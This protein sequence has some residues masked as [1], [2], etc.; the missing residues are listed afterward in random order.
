MS[1]EQAKVSFQKAD[2]SAYPKSKDVYKFDK[3]LSRYALW[4]QEFELRK[5]LSD[6]AADSEIL[7]KIGLDEFLSDEI[8]KEFISE[9]AY[10]LRY[11]RLNDII[12]DAAN[13][14]AKTEKALGTSLPGLQPLAKKV[15]TK[16]QMDVMIRYSLDTPYIL[17][18][19]LKNNSFTDKY[20][21]D[22]EDQ[23]KNQNFKTN[24]KRILIG[25]LLKSK[26]LFGSNKSAGT[27]IYLDENGRFISGEEVYTPLG[28]GS[29][30]LK[31]GF[32]TRLD[33]KNALNIEQKGI[34]DETQKNLLKKGAIKME[35]QEKYQ[36]ATAA[37]TAGTVVLLGLSWWA[38]AAAAIGSGVWSGVKILTDKHGLP[39]WSVDGYLLKFITSIEISN[40][41]H[42]EAVI[43]FRKQT[44]EDKEDTKVSYSIFCQNKSVP[45]RKSIK[46]VSKELL[47]SGGTRRQRPESRG[48][49]MKITSM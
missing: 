18:H 41:L 8:K 29:S 35:E 14:S 34:D 12:Y 40:K 36:F 31:K 2:K 17:Y 42:N 33:K 49:T 37:A 7:K 46:E 44:S 24:K 15:L 9:L 20:T 47:S 48:K 43:Y 39:E 16:A 32:F 10:I 38:F 25:Q 21:D 27:S 30:G 13:R 5:E 1:K 6:A 23:N 22:E 4:L 28:I 45:N 19:I 3:E 11:K 26:K